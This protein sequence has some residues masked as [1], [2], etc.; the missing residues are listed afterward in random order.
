MRHLKAKCRAPPYSRKLRQIRDIERRSK[1]GYQRD[2]K[3]EELLRQELS[4]LPFSQV[5][6]DSKLISCYFVDYHFATKWLHVKIIV[7]QYMIALS[8]YFQLCIEF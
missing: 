7:P 3:T 5:H 2:Q 6:L 1:S 8:Y 4:V